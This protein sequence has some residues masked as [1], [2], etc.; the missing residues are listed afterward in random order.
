MLEFQKAL[1]DD[2]TPEAAIEQIKKKEYCEKLWKEN[3]TNILA[4][5]LSYDTEKKEHQCVIE[6]MQH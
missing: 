4:V 2:D 3:V 5:G 6:K 1:K